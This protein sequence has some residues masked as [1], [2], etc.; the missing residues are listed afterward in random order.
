[1]GYAE[2]DWYREGTADDSSW[3]GIPFPWGII[4]GTTAAFLAYRGVA[5]GSGAAADWIDRHMA[6]DPAA[7]LR[8]EIWQVLTYGFLHDGIASLF[9]N[10]LGL[11]VFARILEDVLPP[12]RLRA[13]FLGGIV[14]G[15]GGVILAAA[16]RGGGPAVPVG[17]LGAAGGIA[18]LIGYGT[19]RTPMAQVVLFL[20]P[21]P[22]W[23]AGLAF[24][25]FPFLLAAGR[26]LDPSAIQCHLAGAAA[27]LLLGVRDR[28]R[29]SSVRR[30]GP[31]SACRICGKPLAR[32]GGRLECPAC[33]V[34]PEPLAPPEPAGPSPAD[35]EAR[36]D[37]LLARIHAE[38]IGALSEE[39]REF[40]KRASERYRG[41]KG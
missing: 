20:I 41:G 25:G 11:W 37:R 9:W 19:V 8:G 17:I 16:A 27:G 18:L 3:K 21:V 4:V 13:L 15:A 5:N 22:L 33:G 34:E 31:G 6:L 24:I 32:I 1:M 14:V 23:V 30:S 10:M 29:P 36:V 26:P 35:V 12:S 7:V 38:G 40:L 39:E 2:R 28:G